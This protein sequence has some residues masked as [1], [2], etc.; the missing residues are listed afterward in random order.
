MPRNHDFTAFLEFRLESLLTI[1]QK[2][3]EHK[4]NQDKT[5]NA[6]LGVCGGENEQMKAI[7]E[8]N[9]CVVVSAQ[10]TLL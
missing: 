3:K 7:T 6:L 2:E 5:K 9:L 1:I 4:S 8:S 10:N